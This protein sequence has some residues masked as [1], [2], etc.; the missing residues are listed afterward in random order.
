MPRGVY[1]R[2]AEHRKRLGDANRGKLRVTCKYG[3]LLVGDNLLLD[4]ST[5]RCRKCRLASHRK[6]SKKWQSRN[7]E[8]CN[9]RTRK[10][11]EKNKDKDR[12]TRRRFVLKKQYGLT[13]EK[14]EEMF[15]FQGRKCANPGCGSISPGRTGWD[16]S[17]D[18]NHTTFRVRGI[19]CNG[20]N[21]ALGLLKESRD[22]I[23]GLAE[24]LK[25]YEGA[26]CSDVQTGQLSELTQSR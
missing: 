9:A 22:R 18:H 20:C 24:Y 15:E 8:K 17:I 4:G 1:E 7:L 12:L 10:W 25:K 2:T 23:L 5:R 13:P 3:H 19:L 16:W 26:K 14:V 21:T 6:A 11:R